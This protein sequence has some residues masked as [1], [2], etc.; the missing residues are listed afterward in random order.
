MRIELA[1]AKVNLCLHV[2]GRREDGM[3]LLDSIVVFPAVGD[4]L[5]ASEADDLTLEIAGPF[6]NGLD[7]GDGNLVIRA[8]RMLSNKGAALRLRKILPVASGIGGG[9]ADAAAS[10]RMLTDLWDVNSPALETLTDLGADVPV[11]MAQVPTRMSG[12]GEKLAALPTL[13]KFW[14]VLCNARQGVET[15][16]VFR[17]MKSRDNPSLSQTPESFPTV[18]NLFEYLRAQRND[19]QTAAIESCPIIADVLSAIEATRNCALS[20]MS[21]SGGTCFGLYAAEVAADEAAKEICENHPDW[22]V[23]SA[24]V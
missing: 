7:A 16:A 12:I 22:W 3:H 4:M 9:S 8:A 1:R 13:P 14:I 19:M 20:R 6:G 23:V 17:A 11:C 15:G 24:Q 21:G 10:I 5:E 2:T 18:D